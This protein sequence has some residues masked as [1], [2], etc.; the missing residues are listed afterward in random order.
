MLNCVIIQIFCIYLH[1]ISE[2]ENKYTFYE[3]KKVSI[4]RG[5]YTTSMV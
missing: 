5:R 1:H 4:A 2:Y 3:S